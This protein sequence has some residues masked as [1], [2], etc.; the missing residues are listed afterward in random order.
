MIL[1]SETFKTKINFLFKNIY[2]LH[3][4]SF[5]K[6][7]P[8][9]KIYINKKCAHLNFDMGAILH[10]Y[11]TAGTCQFTIKRRTVENVQVSLV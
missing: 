1:F 10:R 5:T 3:G 4:L 7:L 6:I 8:I 9:S 11:A 2:F